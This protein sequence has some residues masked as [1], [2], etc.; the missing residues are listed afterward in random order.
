MNLWQLGSNTMKKTA[1]VI[2]SMLMAAPAI[3]QSTINVFP[4]NMMV[5]CGETRNVF[6][7]FKAKF[8]HLG[9]GYN[10]TGNTLDQLVNVWLSNDGEIFVTETMPQGVT[11]IVSAAGNFS[12]V[13]NIQTPEQKSP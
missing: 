9:Y 11:C 5:N 12:F 4:M 3:A 7:V 8:Q 1:I 13:R 10:M 6:D 2:L